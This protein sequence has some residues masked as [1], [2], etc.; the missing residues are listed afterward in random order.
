MRLPT[1]KQHNSILRMPYFAKL[2]IHPKQLYPQNLMMIKAKLNRVHV[3]FKIMPN[4]KLI[5][6]LSNFKHQ[7]FAE[8]K[9]QL[10][11]F[12]VVSLKYLKIPLS[13]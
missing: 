4:L 13:V 10:C 9:V 3:D 6:F 2:P 12:F 7:I 8:I 5:K 1:K 11:C